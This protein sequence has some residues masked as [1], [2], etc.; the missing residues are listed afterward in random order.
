MNG[1]RH[2]CGTDASVVQGDAQVGDL[3]EREPRRFDTKAETLWNPQPLSDVV[4][5]KYQLARSVLPFHYAQRVHVVVV[6]RHLIE[7]SISQQRWRHRDQ[8]LAFAL[9]TS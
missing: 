6:P 9:R 3:T 4:D 1:K 7:L 8:C 2:Q 5:I